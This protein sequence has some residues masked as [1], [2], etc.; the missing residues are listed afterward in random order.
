MDQPISSTS[1]SLVPLVL[2]TAACSTLLTVYSVAGVTP[3]GLAALGL[4]LGPLV[5]ALAWMRADARHRGLGL[6]D[7]IG[8]FLVVAWPLALPRDTVQ[9]RGRDSSPLSAGVLLPEPSAPAP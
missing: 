7:D 9:S 6:V 4:T 2:T 5:A 3:N 1:P 8:L